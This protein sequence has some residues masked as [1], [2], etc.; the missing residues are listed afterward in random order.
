MLS[1]ISS[2]TWLK[3]YDRYGSFGTMIWGSLIVSPVLWF[4]S[5]RNTLSV[6][7]SDPASLG[8]RLSGI[9]ARI[10]LSLLKHHTVTTL[11]LVKS[12]LSRLCKTKNGWYK[13][14]RHTRLRGKS[15]INLVPAFWDCGFADTKALPSV[16]KWGQKLKPFWRY[17][18]LPLLNALK[19]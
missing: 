4:L 5:S 14:L 18:G 6:T 8:F 12:S 9:F 15:H 1:L 19:Y 13:N 16:F 11:R 17:D 10:R 7:H 3:S 2:N